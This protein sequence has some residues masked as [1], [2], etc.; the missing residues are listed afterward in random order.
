MTEFYKDKFNTFHENH[1]S[2]MK[3]DQPAVWQK[4]VKDGGIKSI[5][6]DEMYSIVQG[7]IDHIFGYD[8]LGNQSSLVPDQ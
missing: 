6:K 1:L 2:K 7:F 8:F 5:S 3:A 4:Y